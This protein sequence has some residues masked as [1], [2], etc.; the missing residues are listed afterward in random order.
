M[1]ILS[2]VGG[3]LLVICDTTEHIVEARTAALQLHFVSCAF[4]VFTLFLGCV[5]KQI[6]ERLQLLR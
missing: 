5:G 4:D 2:L 1:V 6:I 3:G